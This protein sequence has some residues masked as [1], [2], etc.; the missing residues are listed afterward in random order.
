[1]ATGRDQRRGESQSDFRWQVSFFFGEFM[2]LYD[3]SASGDYND[4]AEK[5]NLDNNQLFL[6]PKKKME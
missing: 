5:K 2:T 6:P 3:I 1:M 4:Y